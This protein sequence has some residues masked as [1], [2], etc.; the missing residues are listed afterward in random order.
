MFGQRAGTGTAIGTGAGAAMAAEELKDW[1]LGVPSKIART[2][3]AST[4]VKVMIV[5]FMFPPQI[6]SL[7]YPKRNVASYLNQIGSLSQA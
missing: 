3:A 4:T 7:Y 5:L 2:K 6:E 1:A